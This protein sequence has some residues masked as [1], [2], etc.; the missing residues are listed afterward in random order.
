MASPSPRRAHPRLVLVVPRFPKLSETFIIRH[1]VG[2]LDRGVD[3]HVLTRSF[4]RAAFAEHPSLR[5]RSDVQARVHVEPPT[6]PR[7]R[8]FSQL[9]RVAQTWLRHPRRAAAVGTPRH[10]YLESAIARLEP[11][12]VHFEF[13]SLA[14]AR[15]APLRRLGLRTVVSFRGFDL[16]YVGLEDPSYYRDVWRSA[17]AL[18]LLGDDLWRRARRRGCPPDKPHR[19]IPPAVDADAFSA[20]DRPVPDGSRPL[21]LLS[22]GLLEWKKGHDYALRAVRLLLDRGVD[23]RLRILGGG[24]WLG[25]L[26]FMRHQLDLGEHVDIPGPRPHGEVRRE[27]ESADLFLHLSVSEGFGNAVLEA[28]ATGLPVV[29][30]D[31][32]GLR[33]NVAHGETGL[34]VPRRDPAAAADAIESLARDPRRLRQLGDAGPARV[35]RL[36]TLDRE[37]DGFQDLYR[38]ALGGAA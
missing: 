30:S 17:D 27:L 1:A 11:D 14:P 23:V 2:L 37:L 32:D 34:I 19:L 10:L 8:V 16:N 3:V 29:A 28:Q 38:L 4:D 24:E 7:R 6:S 20:P 15:L 5:G 35:R 12:L 25:A 26:C 18:H 31:A 36:F 33:E 13:G 9:P 21:R 22:V